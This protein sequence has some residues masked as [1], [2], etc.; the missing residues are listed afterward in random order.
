M[1]TLVCC[2]FSKSQGGK[3][4]KI[5]ESAF[6]LTE[7]RRKDRGFQPVWWLAGWPCKRYWRSK[8]VQQWWWNCYFVDEG[9]SIKQNGGT[10]KRLRYCETFSTGPRLP[11]QARWSR[12][13][14]GWVEPQGETHPT[15][16]ETSCELKS[17]SDENDELL[18]KTLLSPGA[19]WFIVCLES[20]R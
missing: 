9:Q 3:I 4:Q 16:F 7:E 6:Q 19:F 5:L 14:S 12:R 10:R 20:T 18:P 15:S 1:F 17:R 13:R 11:E 2:N 8:L